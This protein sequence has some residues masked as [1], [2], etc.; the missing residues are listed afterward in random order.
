MLP[1]STLSNANVLKRSTSMNIYLYHKRHRITGL[2]Y[3]GKTTS[4]PI[5]I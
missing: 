5:L 4:N 2:N 1:T 3:F